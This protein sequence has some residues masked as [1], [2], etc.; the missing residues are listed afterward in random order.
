[1]RC[2][3]SVAYI[4]IICAR[5]PLW[6]V[7]EILAEA[8]DDTA[9][10]PCW[11]A[12]TYAFCMSNEYPVLLLPVLLLPVVTFPVAHPTGQVTNHNEQARRF[13][14]VVQ[15]PVYMI[16]V[17]L[18]HVFTLHVLL[19]LLFPVHSSALCIISITY[20]LTS[21]ALGI[22]MLFMTPATLRAS[23]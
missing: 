2:N 15:L 9:V 12:Y 5:Y 7:P 6:T 19:L 17:L 16:P 18:F 21:G 10:N 14:G 11:Y 3:I 4:A 23:K 13:A 8:I 22:V 1:M 20:P